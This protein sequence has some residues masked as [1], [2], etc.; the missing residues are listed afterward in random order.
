MV[1]IPILMGRLY[2]YSNKKVP[3]YLCSDFAKN[4]ASKYIGTFFTR[5]SKCNGAPSK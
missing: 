3:I 5:L 2:K 4:G 1:D